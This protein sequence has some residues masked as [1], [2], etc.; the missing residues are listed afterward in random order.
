MET[1]GDDASCLYQWKASPGTNGIT[2]VLGKAFARYK[3]ETFVTGGL[4]MAPPR[5]CEEPFVSSSSS[6]RYKCYSLYQ[7][8]IPCTNK[9]SS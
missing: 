1:E 6:T 8:K 2:F 7:G 5:P 9:K 4:E 3:C